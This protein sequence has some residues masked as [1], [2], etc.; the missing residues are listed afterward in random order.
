MREK[1][2]ILFLAADPFRSGA[3]LA[4]D[5]EARAIDH[6]IQRGAA[7]D[8][9]ELVSHFATRTRDLHHALL[10]HQPRVVHFAGHGDAPG[11]IVLGDEQGRPKRVDKDALAHLFGILDSVRVVVLN[12][13]DTLPTV[14]ALSEVVDC[15]IGM[16]RPITDAAALVFAEAF[17]GA[18]AFG[19]G[20][21]KAFAL[22]VNQLRIEGTAE[23]DVPVLRARSTAGAARALHA[24]SIPSAIAPSPVQSIRTKRGMVS[25]N[26]DAENGQGIELGDFS[27]GGPPRLR[28]G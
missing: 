13:C 24:A 4:L 19:T 27:A 16:N 21:E 5:E 11:V 23:A 7:R 14:E 20:V 9:L 2:K 1:I 17:Y 15:A 28:N 8:A 3:R 6:A 25:Q 22:A 18:L 12:G 26:P 10:R